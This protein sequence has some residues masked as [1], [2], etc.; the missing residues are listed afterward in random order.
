MFYKELGKRILIL[1]GA[2]GT[3]L[4]KYDLSMKDFAGKTKNCFE[5]LNETRPDIIQE[6]HKKYI[7]A[8]ADIIETNSFNCNAISLKDYELE[9]RVFDLA[10]KSAEIARKATEITNRK[11]YVLGSIGPTN[12]SLTFLK[13]NAAYEKEP[14]FFDFKKA[15][16]E[17]IKGLIA[18]GVDGLLIETIFDTLNAK[19]AVLAA[20]ESYKDLE[21]N[22]PICISATVNR[23]G[24]LL[25]GETIEYLIESLDRPSILSFGFNC[26]FGT[27]DL[28]PLIKKIRKSTD[29]FISLYPNAGLPNQN[30]DYKETAEKMKDNL[31]TLIENKEINILG[32]CCGTTYEHIEVLANLI[33]GK[34]TGKLAKK[35]FKK[36]K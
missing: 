36:K 15:Y 13:K 35:I 5:L 12:K 22:L 33:K 29:K 17:Q 10:K 4:M 3:T 1:D 8:G 30:G 19:A 25:T 27:K 2:M 18:G 7:E 26:S 11:V 28:A 24:K 32:G 20:E 16:K 23:Q 9:N 31:L 14:T 21:L 6:V 34:E